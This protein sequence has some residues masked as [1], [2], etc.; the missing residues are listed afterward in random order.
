MGRSNPRLRNPHRWELVA[1]FIFGVVFL[2]TLLI[3]AIVTPNPTEFQIFIYRVVLAIAAAGIGALI[4]GVIVVNIRPYIRAGGAI[5][6]FVIIFWF[7]PPALVTSFTPFEEA[8][9]RG[10]AALAA[11]SHTAAISFFDKA[12]QAKP[13]SWIPY[14]GLGRAYYKQGNF[15]LA[16]EQ[17]EKAFELGGRKDGSI[18]YVMATAQDGLKQYEAAEK[19]LVLAAELLPSDSQLVNEV[20]FDRGLVNLILWL[21]RDAPRDT[22]RYRDAEFAFQNFIERRGLPL[23][24]ARYSLACLKATRGED[25]SLS[26]ADV[27]ALR[28]EANDKLEQAVKELA[29]YQSSKA[30]LQRQMMRSLLLT[31]EKWA[32]KPGEPTACPALIR[33]W[34][35]ARGSIDML[36]AALS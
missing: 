28:A 17:F 2:A 25:E 31:P 22:Q 33:S 11:D 26:P 12:R 1:V 15:A 36:A 8:V 18:A 7:N 21:N 23:H 19:N 9:R 24:W 35:G 32:R 34:A 4:P 3:I 14:Y 10:E 5:V 20:I 13:E 16:S 30:P 6:V 27:A 29:V